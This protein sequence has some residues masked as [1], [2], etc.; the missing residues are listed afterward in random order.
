MLKRN[1]PELILTAF[2][3]AVLAALIVLT[4]TATQWEK[5]NGYPFGRMCYSLFTGWQDT[6]PAGLTR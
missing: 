5:A 1:L 4:P 3:V 6:C 2:T